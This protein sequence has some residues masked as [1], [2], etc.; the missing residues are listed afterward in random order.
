MRDTPTKSLRL[1][2]KKVL[3]LGL[4]V[5]LGLHVIVM[6]IFKRIDISSTIDSV[7]LDVIQVEDIPQTEQQKQTQAPARPTVPIASEDEDLPEDETIDFTDWDIN[8]AAPPPPPPEDDEAIVF[9]PYDEPPE[10]VGGFAAIQKRLKYPEIARK[11]GVEGRVLVYAQVDEQGVVQRT[12][13]IQSLGPNGCDEA[14][15]AAIKSVKWK[16]AKQRDRSVKVW[17]AVPVDFRLR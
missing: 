9:V 6:Q 17:I 10:P 5:S 12:R 14:A 1:N 13:V 3:E 2:Y 16:P 15:E 8:D 4:I 7:K 11:A